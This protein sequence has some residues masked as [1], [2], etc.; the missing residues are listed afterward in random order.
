MKKALANGPHEGRVLS[1][2]DME[3]MKSLY[4][5]LRGWDADGKPGEEKL[6][7]LGL[8]NLNKN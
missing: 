5:H 7:K 4:Y 6:R 1:S 2:E 8:E 3:E